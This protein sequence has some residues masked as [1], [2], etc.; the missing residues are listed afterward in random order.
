M[1]A[2]PSLQRNPIVN[3]CA[4]V[5]VLYGSE[6]GNANDVALRQLLA[7]DAVPPRSVADTA[8]IDS[9]RRRDVATDDVEADITVPSV[10][11]KAQW[12]FFLSYFLFLYLLVYLGDVVLFFRAYIN[13]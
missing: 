10:P 3:M 1:W 9:S 5:L 2:S 6:T 11:A 7:H 13:I 12:C 8:C 4:D